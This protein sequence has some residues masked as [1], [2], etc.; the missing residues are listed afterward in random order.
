MRVN[1][2]FSIWSVKLIK[3]IIR[4]TGKGRG[5]SMPGKLARILDGDILRN[6]AK[7]TN[8]IIIT[9][10]NGKTTTSNLISAILGR[11]GLPVINNTS[12]NNLING[13][14]QIYVE[15]AQELKKSRTKEWAVI[16]C[17]EATIVPLLKE[18]HPVVIVINNFFRDQLDRYGEIDILIN[19]MHEAIAAT[20]ARLILNTDDPFVARFSDLKNKKIYFGISKNAYHFEKTSVRESLYCPNC[21][22]KLMYEAMFYSQLGYYTCEHCGFKRQIPDYEI[23]KIQRNNKGFLFQVTEKQQDEAGTGSSPNERTSDYQLS[24]FGVHNLYNALSAVSVA[25][26]L[27]LPNEAIFGGL[28]NYK[29]KNGRMTIYHYNGTDRIVNLIKNPASADVAIG[30]IN[31]DPQNKSVV[32]FLNDL[33]A[34]G[35][36]VSWIW[37]VDFERLAQSSISNFLCS[38][39]RAWE[40]ANRLKYADIDPNKIKVVPEIGKAMDFSLV[41]FTKTY[42]LPNYTALNSVNNYLVNKSAKENQEER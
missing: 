31:Y 17:D 32:F 37:D 3:R 4:A 7:R 28:E 38:G 41:H 36:D 13:I 11:G 16:E 27:N 19:K 14:T 22:S 15:K 26:E 42:Y 25:K 20:D 9:G 34:D 6:L 10:T 1:E 12:G 2:L 5:E 8:T 35:N 24:L 33:T 21:G 29:L 18:V 23:K 40:M 39:R 30:E